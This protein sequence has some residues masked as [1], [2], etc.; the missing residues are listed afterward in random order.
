VPLPKNAEILIDD[1]QSLL[2]FLEKEGLEV[3][4]KK[5]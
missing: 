5:K 1:E 4:F 3:P 2:A